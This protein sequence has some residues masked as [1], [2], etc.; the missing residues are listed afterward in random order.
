LKFPPN[1]Q[2]WP[3]G[4]SQVVPSGR[5]FLLEHCQG[6]DGVIVTRNNT[7]RIHKL[8]IFSDV[9]SL[10]GAA[11][12]AALVCTL[13]MSTSILHVMVDSVEVV[14]VPSIIVPRSDPT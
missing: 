11:V 8:V 13:M 2:K 9:L 5:Y 4:C 14:V 6:T 7:I 12:N 1:H 10:V 3:A